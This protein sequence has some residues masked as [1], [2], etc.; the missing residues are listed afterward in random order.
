MAI[1]RDLSDYTYHDAFKAPGTK[2]IGWL[3][4]GVAYPQG[5]VEQIPVAQILWQYCAVSIAE[6]RGLHVCD[7][8]DKHPYGTFTNGDKSLI[9]GGAEIRVFSFDRRTLFAA[10]NLIFLYVADH[11]YLPP[12]VFVFVF[13]F[14][15]APPDGS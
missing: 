3:G 11:N 13:S 1:Y 5:V 7:L 9:L 12:V 6:S 14:C 10:P 2:N 15:A 8:C 4:K